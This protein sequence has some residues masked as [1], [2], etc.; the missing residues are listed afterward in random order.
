MKL[1]VIT[2]IIVQGILEKG[3]FIKLVV[4]VKMT[5]VIL[6]AIYEKLLRSRTRVTV[7]TK[8]SFP[9]HFSF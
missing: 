3:T 6:Y 2:K 7:Y 8:Y 4:S 5:F 1:L 9:V